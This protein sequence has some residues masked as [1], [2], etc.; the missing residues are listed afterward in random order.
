[1][2]HP[3]YQT[4]VIMG[5]DNITPKGTPHLRALVDIKSNLHHQDSNNTSIILPKSY[6][7]IH[8][9]NLCWLF[10][11]F[12]HP[13]ILSLG[14]F[15]SSL[16]QIMEIQMPP[17]RNKALILGPINR[18]WVSFMIPSSRDAARWSCA[19]PNGRD[20]HSTS[21]PLGCEASWCGVQKET[22]MKGGSFKKVLNQTYFWCF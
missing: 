3:T 17:P 22:V 15:A 9:W 21:W 1:M 19:L 10:P 5:N 2:D 20:P 7:A 11:Y 13:D 8:P 12:F 16:A 14:I 4:A 6:F 18:Q